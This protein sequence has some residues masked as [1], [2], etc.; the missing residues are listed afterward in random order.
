MDKAL[1]MAEFNSRAHFDATAR[2]H[3]EEIL[4][5]EPL[6]VMIVVEEQDGNVW[7][8][9]VPFSMALIKGL[10]HTAVDLAWAEEEA[11]D[12]GD[13]DDGGE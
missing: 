8:T 3:L 11:E 9:S 7:M 1:I 12:A 4:K 13:G 10:T 6:S 2:Q 5:L